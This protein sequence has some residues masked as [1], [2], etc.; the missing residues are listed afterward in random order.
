MDINVNCNTLEKSFYDW[1]IAF[2]PI[3]ISGAVAVIV[4]FQYKVNK[5][6]FRLDLY[7]RR[8]SVY[9]KSLAYFQSYSSSDSTAELIDS[10]AR[11]FIHVF[12]ES[13]FLFGKDSEVY[14]VQEELKVTLSFLVQFDREFNSE[15]YDNDKYNVWSL[16]KQSM[17]DPH[18][19][20]EDLENALLPW[21][22][23]KKID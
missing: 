22:D 3:L 8:F 23:F 19:I 17:R 13:I 2:T 6:K 18:K 4:Y 9:E 10:C 16:R 5:H 7:N 15:S 14:K 21:L 11:D 12:R 1:A 20:M